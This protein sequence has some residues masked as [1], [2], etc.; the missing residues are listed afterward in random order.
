MLKAVAEFAGGWNVGEIPPEDYARKL[1]VLRS[2]CQDVG[3]DFE[4]IEK[5]LETIVLISDKEEE[6]QRVVNWSNWFAGI[7]SETKEMKPAI[8]NLST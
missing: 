4:H 8:G 3:T 5:S 1:R 2:H 7:Q 6:L